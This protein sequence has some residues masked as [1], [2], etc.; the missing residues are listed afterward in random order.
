M[1]GSLLQT[2]STALDFNKQSQSS[3][4][5]TVSP[6]PAAKKSSLFSS[7]SRAPK[8]PLAAVHTHTLNVAAGSATAAAGAGPAKQR[9]PMDRLAACIKTA[10]G[11]LVPGRKR[12]AKAAKM[13]KTA[14]AQA[15]APARSAS[16]ATSM[17][18]LAKQQST[19]QHLSVKNFSSLALDDVEVVAAA[20]PSPAVA[21]VSTP[22]AG[23]ASEVG[24][25]TS[26]SSTTAAQADG[27]GTDF[28]DEGLATESLVATDPTTEI[29]L[30]ISSSLTPEAEPKIQAVDP[31]AIIVEEDIME[32]GP[33][34]AVERERRDSGVAEDI[35]QGVAAA[36]AAQQQLSVEHQ[37]EQSAVQLQHPVEQQDDS[38]QQ[39][40]A[41]IAPTT[42]AVSEPEQLAAVPSVLAPAQISVVVDSAPVASPAVAATEIPTAATSSAISHV[43][44]VEAP[45]APTTSAVPKPELAAVPSVLAP[46]QV[47][48]VVNS[49]PAASPV[50]EDGPLA[51]SPAVAR[52]AHAMLTL[53]RVFPA[54]ASLARAQ[55]KNIATH[56]APSHLAV[57]LYK[58]AWSSSAA[59]K[60]GTSG[61]VM[62][63][64]PVS[65]SR[66]LCPVEFVWWGSRPIPVALLRGTTD[67]EKMAD[68]TKVTIGQLYQ[69]VAAALPDDELERLAVLDEVAA[70]YPAQLKPLALVLGFMFLKAG[71]KLADAVT[72][73]LALWWFDGRTHPTVAPG[74]LDTVGGEQASDKIKAVWRELLAAGAREYRDTIR[75]DFLT[76]AEFMHDKR[77][78]DDPALVRAMAKAKET[79]KPAEQ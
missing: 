6:K 52:L 78:A 58:Y 65:V 5:S 17:A 66:T 45:I 15:S 39:L 4:R 27:A 38:V 1:N 43:V 51:Q 74:A 30:P 7:S 11:R 22:P 44:H 72:K 48:V 60:C 40:E 36:L 24:T 63:A 69:F 56:L 35:A 70:A 18:R 47:S 54:T 29:P 71:S 67:A 53:L 75:T 26:A 34:E 68:T 9:S 55:A 28:E 12:A 3:A 57:D 64:T 14:A 31:I 61:Q 13:A 33:V 73:L 10:F 37:Q 79:K 41:L 19:S 8:V 21:S 59:R 16:P 49:A 32:D 25:S 20:A 77:T 42:T 2:T 23:T 46:V 50:V 62:L 76:P